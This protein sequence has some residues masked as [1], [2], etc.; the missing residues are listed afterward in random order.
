MQ[1]PTRHF[2]WHELGHPP[3]KHQATTRHLAHHL[4]HLRMLKSDRPLT[5]LSAYR[6]PS[7]NRA[8]GGATRSLHLEGAAA[9]IPKGYARTADAEAAGFVGIGSRDGWAVHVDVRD[10]PPARWTY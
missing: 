3:A 9:D 4:E 1:S 5:I 10:G 2:S 6:D 8:V 7:R